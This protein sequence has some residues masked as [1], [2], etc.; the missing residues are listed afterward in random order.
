MEIDT[1]SI[2]EKIASKMKLK[3]KSHEKHLL[4]MAIKQY[5]SVQQDVDEAPRSRA[6]LTTLENLK[7]KAEAFSYCIANLDNSTIRLLSQFESDDVGEMLSQ[8][9][10]RDTL[11]QTR[12]GAERLSRYAESYIKISEGLPKD[13]GGQR[14]RIATFFLISHL[15]D[16]YR[17]Y[18]RD[19]CIRLGS[20]SV[21]KNKNGEWEIGEF[22]KFVKSCLDV[23]EPPRSKSAVAKIIYNAYK[24]MPDQFDLPE[25]CK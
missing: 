18:K 19:P 15:A 23:L 25:D 21:Y 1:S 24:A 12:D 8:K 5:L 17:M 20:S 14:K 7:K 6:I 9:R 3:L 11:K 2:V 22:G 13:K 10:I 4:G 16:I